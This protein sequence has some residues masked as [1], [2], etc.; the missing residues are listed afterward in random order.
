MGSRATALAPVEGGHRPIQYYCLN[1][2][3]LVALAL[4]GLASAVPGPDAY[5]GYRGYYRPYYYGR[6]WYGKRQAEDE[7]AASGPNPDADADAH[8]WGYGGYYRPYYHGYY[9]G[10]RQA[11]DEPAAS[12][13]NPDA[14]AHGW[15]YGGYYRPY[16]H[17][18]YGK[19]SANPNPQYQGWAVY[20]GG[21][22]GR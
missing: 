13:P 6:G 18:H 12:G 9:Y 16:Y 1:M 19:R 7:T 22:Y 5:Y 15:G 2:K 17:G 10:K 4:L 11:E 21:H 8:G 20:S 3:L 14:D